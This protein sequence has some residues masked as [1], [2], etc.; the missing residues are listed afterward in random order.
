DGSTQVERLLASDAKRR[1]CRYAIESTPMPVR[2]YVGALRVEDNCDGTS[3]VTWSAHFDAAEDGD[4]TE[5]V[6]GFPK[7]GV[8]R[9]RDAYDTPDKEA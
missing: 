1:T 4:A 3:T 9:L 6:R 8:D 2:N 7:A 5:M